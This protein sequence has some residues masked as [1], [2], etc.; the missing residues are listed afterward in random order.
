M[1]QATVYIED[2]RLR[3]IVG[4]NDWE[5]EKEQDIIINICF[6]YDAC[7]AAEKD[8]IETAVDYKALKREIIAFVE[9]SGFFL[10]ERLCRD[11]L[12]LILNEERVLWAKVRI[13]KPHALRYA[14]SVAVEMERSRAPKESHE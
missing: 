11:I 8:A 9:K 3:A 4:T 13:D 14:K 2:L 1:T 7:E 6:R 5:R 12:T 10:L